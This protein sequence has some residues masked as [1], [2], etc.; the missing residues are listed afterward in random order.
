MASPGKLQPLPI[1]DSIWTNISMDFIEGLP[2]SQGKAQARM[3]QHNDQH[4]GERE[5]SV[6]DWVFLRL[7]PYKQTSVQTKAS[8][9]LSPWFYEPY[10]I[11]ECI[12]AV[13]YRLDLP[14]SSRIHP[15]FHVPCLKLKMG[16]IET[17]QSHLPNMTTQEDL[18][19]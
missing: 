17:A 1:P 10:Q 3:K 11:L 7:Q 16:Q 4:K 5:F 9:K 12:G 14:A 2:S 18:Q 13:V 19:T 15:V 8:M 6:G